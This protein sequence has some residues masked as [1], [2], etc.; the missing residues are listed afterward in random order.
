MK[1]HCS[2]VLS[3]HIVTLSSPNV[4]LTAGHRI[5]P[6]IKVT[7]LNIFRDLS[8]KII[9]KI[10]LIFVV[11]RDTSPTF[12]SVH[13]LPCLWTLYR[14]IN[15]KVTYDFD[16]WNNK[17]NFSSFVLYD[18]VLKLMEIKHQVYYPRCCFKTLSLIQYHQYDYQP[19]HRSRS[20]V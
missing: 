14:L 16:T 12:C 17:N 4:K 15:V 19:W 8:S 2:F 1:L 9:K 3:N 6:Q 18:I 20:W 10:Q 11:F 5:V 13:Q 7:G